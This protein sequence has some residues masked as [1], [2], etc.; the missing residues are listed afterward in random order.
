M[1][2]LLHKLDQLYEHFSVCA[3]L[4]MIPFPYQILLDVAVVLY[5]SIVHQG[6]SAAF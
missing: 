2:A 1:E 3:A 6:E 4:E 5:D